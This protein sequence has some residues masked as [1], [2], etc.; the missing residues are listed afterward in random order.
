[1]ALLRRIAQAEERAALAAAFAA[2]KA[3]QNSLS[4]NSCDI[5][6]PG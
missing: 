2:A 6:P 4:L 3:A 5:H 1:M